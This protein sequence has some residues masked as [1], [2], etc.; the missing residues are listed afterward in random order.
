[1]AL[2]PVSSLDEI[3]RL[4]KLGE[5][6]AELSEF[7]ETGEGGENL[8]LQRCISLHNGGEIDLVALPSQ[9]AFVELRQTRSLRLKTGTYPRSIGSPGLV[10]PQ[11][12]FLP[13]P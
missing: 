12:Q 10:V 11:F 9:A 2:A 7:H 1:M 13:H 4:Y 3:V 8:F 6:P 5:L